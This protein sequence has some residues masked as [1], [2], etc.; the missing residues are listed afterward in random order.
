MIAGDYKNIMAIPFYEDDD[1][2]DFKSVLQNKIEELA[3]VDDEVLIFVDL[4]GATPFNF[5]GQIFEEL[6]NK[7]INIRVISGMNLPMILE[8]VFLLETGELS[9]DELY[10]DIIKIGKNGITELCEELK[11][12]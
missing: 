11:L 2:L 5:V 12:K 9:V 3:K 6:K 8:S 1:L 10:E 4:Y 7:N